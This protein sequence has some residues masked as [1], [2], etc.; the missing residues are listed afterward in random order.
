VFPSEK[1]EAYLEMQN[2]CL[3]EF[4][5][6][7]FIGRV[8]STKSVGKINYNIYVYVS[9]GTLAGLSGCSLIEKED[10]RNIIITTTVGRMQSINSNRR[11]L[12]ESD[13]VVKKLGSEL[14]VVENPSESFKYSFFYPRPN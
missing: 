6:M 8:I 3:K 11:L 4:V 1:K 10:K 9:E 5:E 12:K 2:I 14:L 7:E 13:V